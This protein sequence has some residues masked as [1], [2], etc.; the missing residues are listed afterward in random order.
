MTKKWLLCAWICALFLWSL[1][2][3][4]FAEGIN[5]SPQDPSKAAEGFQQMSRDLDELS[6][7]MAPVLAFGGFLIGAVMVI[8]GLIFSKRMAKGGF[9]LSI[10][11]GFVFFLLSDLST[12]VGWTKG[13][14]E[15]LASYFK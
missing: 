13:F 10:A 1:S 2:G 8:L 4:A 11:S 3:V 7:G 15:N 12:A 5:V 6:S 14:F 9:F